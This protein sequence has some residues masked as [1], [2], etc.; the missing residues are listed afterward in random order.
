M[1]AFEVSKE[2]CH[3]VIFNTIFKLIAIIRIM[4]VDIKVAGIILLGS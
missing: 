3:L 2:R 4:L 1:K